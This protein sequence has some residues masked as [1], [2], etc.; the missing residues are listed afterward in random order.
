MILR[1]SGGV[2]KLEATDPLK[3]AP[4]SINIQYE[5]V[6]CTSYFSVWKISSLLFID[7]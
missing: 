6:Y 2:G 7:I 1:G 3:G 5:E 4:Q